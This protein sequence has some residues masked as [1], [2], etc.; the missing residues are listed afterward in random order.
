MQLG[1][2]QANAYIYVCICR[3]S[4]TNT[5]FYYFFLIKNIVGPFQESLQQVS[6]LSGD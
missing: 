2:R 1:L 5:F 3:N 4:W 6:S